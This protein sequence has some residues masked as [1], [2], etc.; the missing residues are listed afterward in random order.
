M[1]DMTK[2]NITKVDMIERQCLFCKEY[3]KGS[4]YKLDI[5]TVRDGMDTMIFE[6]LCNE[7]F[8]ALDNTFDDRRVDER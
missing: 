8:N 5:N 4:F 6:Q 7:C 2:V 3:I 1:I